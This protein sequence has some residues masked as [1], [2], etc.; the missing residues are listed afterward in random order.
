[1]YLRHADGELAGK[2]TAAEVYIKEGGLNRAM[3]GKR[4][5]LVDVP[6]SAG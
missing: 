4:C 6:T 5:D 1:M 2:V 3:T